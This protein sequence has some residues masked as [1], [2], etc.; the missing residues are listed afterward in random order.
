M[1][2]CHPLRWCIEASH[3]VERRL[4]VRVQG[5]SET[6][7]ANTQPPNG[8]IHLFDVKPII[9][10]EFVEGPLIFDFNGVVPAMGKDAPDAA[11]LRL[12]I[13]CHMRSPC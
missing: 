6:G 10:D 2:G 1:G 5:D 7:V 8:L 12:S 3:N 11:G 4:S 9:Y 13:V